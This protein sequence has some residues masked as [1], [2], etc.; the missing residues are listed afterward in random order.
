MRLI[1]KLKF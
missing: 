1:F